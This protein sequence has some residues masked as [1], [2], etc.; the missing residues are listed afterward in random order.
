MLWDDSATMKGWKHPEEFANG[1]SACRT[2]G[3]LARLDKTSVQV[4][5]SRHDLRRDKDVADYW[6]DAMTIP[7][8]VVRR[9]IYLRRGDG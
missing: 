7:R 8:S 4:I 1:I 9:I 6:A 3:Y 5:Q 2:V